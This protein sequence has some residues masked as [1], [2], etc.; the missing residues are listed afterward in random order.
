MNYLVPGVSF[1][2]S[3]A[4]VAVTAVAP[5]APAFAGTHE[6]GDAKLVHCYGVNTCK[7]QSDCKTAHND[8]KG[9]NSCKGHGFKSMTAQACEAAGGSLTEAE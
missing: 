3:A 9:M 1:A 2:A 8:C 5:I 6:G 4:L 7:G